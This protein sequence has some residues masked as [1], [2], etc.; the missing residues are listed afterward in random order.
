M[1]LWSY[2]VPTQETDIPHIA[3]MLNG[4]FF[5]QGNVGSW[6]REMLKGKHQHVL[7]GIPIDDKSTGKALAW[8][9]PPP[10]SDSNAT[11]L[12]PVHQPVH[13]PYNARK[14]CKGLYISTTVNFLTM[15]LAEKA[16]VASS[17]SEDEKPVEARHG[18]QHGNEEAE[19]DEQA[20][21]AEEPVRKR[22][23]S[24]HEYQAPLQDTSLFPEGK[25]R[26]KYCD[27][28]EGDL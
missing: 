21:H 9:A 5:V 15:R 16:K 20:E 1:S 8:C 25:Y 22:H 18:V 12:P 10:D 26:G 27:M 14:P 17:G 2:I 28:G 13:V 23:K 7:K 19:P 6:L 4:W 3:G 11:Y 24:W